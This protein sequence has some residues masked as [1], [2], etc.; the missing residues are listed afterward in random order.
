[1]SISS[2]LTIGSRAMTANYA[3]LQTTGNNVA[4]ANTAGYSRQSVELATAFSQQTGS[5]FFGKG[6]DV[7]T[8]SRAH[9][10]FLTR[11][12]ATTAS[13][14]A[15]DQ[16]RSSQLQQLETVFATGEAGLGYSAQQMFNAFVDVSNKP[17]DSSARQVALARVGDLATRFR[18]ASDQIDSIQSGIAQDLR[19]A[20][21]SINAL[22]VRIADLNQRIANAKGTG[23]EPNDLL[24]Q[25]DTAIADLSKIAQVTTV[26]AADGTVGVFLGGAQKL[27][28]G[29]ESTPLTALA[30][31]Y[32]PAKVQIGISEGGT[33]RAFPDGFVAGGSAAGLLRVQNHDLGDARGLLGQLASA[34]AGSVN[35]QQA[36]GLDLGQPAGAGAP[37]LAIGAA[38]VAP[39]SNNAKAGGVP[40][41]SYVNGL[42][43]RVPSVSIAVV[44]TSELQPSDYELVADPSLPAGSYR[45][46][47]LSDGA[48]QTVSDGSIVDG[49][50][51]DIAAPAPAARDRFLLQPVSP[52][53]RS[54]VRSL[55]DPKG[56]AAASPVTATVAAT[57]TGTATVASLAAVSASINPNLTATITFTDNSGNY[58]YSLVDTTSVLPTVNGTGTFVAGQPIALNGF[59]LKLN[60]SAKLG[61]SLVV[62]KTAYPAGDNGNANALLALRDATFVGQRTISPGVVAPGVNV[63]D[64]YASALASIGVRVQSASL[65]ADQSA[66]VASDAKTAEA[67]KSGVNLDEEAARLIQYQQSYQAAAK[68][69]QIAQS[70]FDTLLKIGN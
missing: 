69:L 8:V 66:Q 34:I 63:T 29:G 5:G 59:A 13:L 50:R 52:A 17:Q 60:G 53:T 6:V 49:F 46:T 18:T 26:A 45:L 20:V 24:D 31:P 9:S 1:M 10:D 12:A 33:T 64:A 28:L 36:L 25:R 70:V 22:T 55:D 23:H 54:I 27:V 57:N 3:A 11:E 43:V 2:L 21:T 32:D 19:T 4:N 44:S 15:A 14:A 42:G 41:A 39:S 37:L 68:M 47:R 65:A 7:A 30:D 48:A 51:I 16:A 40:V 58:S 35:A 56:I 67:E 62:A 61:D 38:A